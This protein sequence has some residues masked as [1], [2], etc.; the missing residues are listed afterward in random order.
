MQG[1]RDDRPPAARLLGR[2]VLAVDPEKRS[3]EVS[4]EAIEG[5]TNR[6]GTV[7]GG[8]LAAML[9]SAAGNAL[10]ASLQA[11]QSAVTVRL[12]TRFLAPASAGTL[13]A[14]AQVVSASDRTAEV[15]A[16][17]LDEDGRTVAT[18]RAEMRIFRKAL[19]SAA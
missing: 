9:D 14:R 13:R 7:Q 2:R 15:D 10:I 3:V 18:A 16:S 19:G 5:F 8:F 11:D 6:H 17:L 1:S 12:D 4:F